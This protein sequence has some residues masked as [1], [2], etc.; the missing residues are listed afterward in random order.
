MLKKVIAA[1]LDE[2]GKQVKHEAKTEREALIGLF[3]RFPHLGNGNF[4]DVAVYFEHDL[5]DLL[6]ELDLTYVPVGACNEQAILV[7][8]ITTDM[9]KMFRAM[10]MVCSKGL[11]SNK[12]KALS[13]LHPSPIYS[14]LINEGITTSPTVWN[15][16]YKLIGSE[17]RLL[18]NETIDEVA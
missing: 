17:F 10:D 4:E 8:E 5:T 18:F 13:G 16:A 1:G 6:K 2:D 14:I 3:E 7:D 9:H 15:K 12:L 11:V